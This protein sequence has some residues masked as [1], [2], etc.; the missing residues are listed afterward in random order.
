MEDLFC[1]D[2]LEICGYFIEHNVLPKPDLEKKG[3]Y[4]FTPENS[5][6]FDELFFEEQGIPVKRDRELELKKYMLGVK[7]NEE[8]LRAYLGIDS[9]PTP[10]ENSKPSYTK[11]R[12]KIGRNDPCPCG[13][14]I[15][16]KWCCGSK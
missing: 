14:G 16:H 13:S 12:Q 8:K 3:M 10:I 5:T 2:E 7:D 6:M 4:I 9:E 15:K 11:P 1:G